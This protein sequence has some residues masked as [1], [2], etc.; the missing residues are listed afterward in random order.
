M[1]YPVFIAATRLNDYFSELI[2]H[3]PLGDADDA[4][5]YRSAR[6]SIHATLCLRDLIKWEAFRTPVPPEVTRVL[7]LVLKHLERDLDFETRSNV[8]ENIDT[9]PSFE[10]IRGFSPEDREKVF[11]VEARVKADLATV[12]TYLK[13]KIAA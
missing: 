7:P 1:S 12:I 10:S 13:G 9:H 4:L 11:A 8:K 2:K 3:C 5:V 6:T